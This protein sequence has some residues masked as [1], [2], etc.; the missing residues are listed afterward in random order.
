MKLTKSKLK[1]IIKEEL[2]E[3]YN[4]QSH[5]QII[6]DR[7]ISALLEATYDFDPPQEALNEL[8]LKA[9]ELLE[10]YLLGDAEFV[11]MLDNITGTSS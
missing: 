1:Q 5:N 6:I 3:A 2:K 8:E 7:M 11:S 9:R 10:R 4:P